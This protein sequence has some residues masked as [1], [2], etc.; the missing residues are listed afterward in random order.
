MRFHACEGSYPPAGSR[1]SYDTPRLACVASTESAVTDKRCDSYSLV[2]RT[3]SLK[4]EGVHFIVANR[5]C[6]LRLIQTQK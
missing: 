3:H 4:R 5:V 6:L 1:Q 2:G